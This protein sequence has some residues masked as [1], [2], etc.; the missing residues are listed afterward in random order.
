[1]SEGD[2]LLLKACFPPNTTRKQIRSAVKPRLAEGWRPAPFR[3]RQRIF[4][5]IITFH[6]KT[7]GVF[8]GN[9]RRNALAEWPYR[10]RL[11]RPHVGTHVEFGGRYGTF[12]RSARRHG[13]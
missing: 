9:R 5:Y 7:P 6:F 8:I 11:K 13:Y 2:Q 4:L 10:L 1:M 12:R 3:I